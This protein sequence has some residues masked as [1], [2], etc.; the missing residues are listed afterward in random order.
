MTKV[1]LENSK[2]KLLSFKA[3]LFL[4]KSEISNRLKYFLL[5]VLKIISYF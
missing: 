3:I 5:L 4:F 2:L 1:E